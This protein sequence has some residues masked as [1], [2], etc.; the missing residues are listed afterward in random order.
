[1]SSQLLVEFLLSFSLTLHLHLSQ[2]CESAKIDKSQGGIKFLRPKKIRVG[3]ILAGIQ[4]SNKGYTEIKQLCFT[5]QH[6]KVT[7]LTAVKQ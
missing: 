2:S 5:P 4:K 6:S 1:M 3:I 7:D